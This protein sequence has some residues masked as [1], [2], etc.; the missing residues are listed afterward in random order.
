M[1]IEDFKT[2]LLF[3]LSALDPSAPC[4]SSYSMASIS[5]YVISC[6]PHISYLFMLS[7]IGPS[8]KQLGVVF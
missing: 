5:P 1:Y 3:S 8:V 6:D 7:R 2:G 4:T